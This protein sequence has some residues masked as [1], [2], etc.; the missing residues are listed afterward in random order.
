VLSGQRAHRGDQLIAHP[1]GDELGEAAVAVGDA[2][3][4]VARVDEPARGVGEPLQHRLDR[5]LGGDRQ[6]RV[7]HRAQGGAL[8]FHLAFEDTPGV[9]RA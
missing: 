5:R 4:G 3:G 2:D 1:R 7:V 9:R 8:L 6:H